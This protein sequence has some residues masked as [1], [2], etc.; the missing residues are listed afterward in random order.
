MSDS[1]LATIYVSIDAL[2]DTRLSILHAMDP[3]KLDPVVEEKYFGRKFD[4]FD[5][6]NTK[7]F[8]DRYDKRDIAA[9]KD[10]M[11]TGIIPIISYFAKTTLKARV[12]TPFRRQPKLELNIYPY[13]LSEKAIKTIIHGL[14]IVTEGLIDIEV[15]RY[16]LE[17]LT[18]SFVK[19]NY[20]DMVMYDYWNWLE[21]HAKNKNFESVQCPEVT[22]I[23]PML[24][25]SRE[26]WEECKAVDIFPIIEQYSSLFI[27][28]VLYPVSYFCV[29]LER[30][31]A[32]R[33]SEQ[34]A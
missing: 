24:V 23:G 9:L 18:P 25:K 17:E 5:G 8:Q 28:L 11:I 20:I 19:S 2:F 16:S 31:S 12:S 29:D 7:S 3:A 4:E 32:L 10:A 1:D 34:P 14:K 30:L 15:V 21:C 26:A 22:L 33:Q 27:K 6:Y 13:N